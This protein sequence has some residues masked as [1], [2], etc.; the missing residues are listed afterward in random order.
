MST[1]ESAIWHILGYA[2]IPIIVIFG[3]VISA[4]VFYI[5]LNIFAAGED[6]NQ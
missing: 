4:M 2:A 3:I 1:F 5:L 6:D